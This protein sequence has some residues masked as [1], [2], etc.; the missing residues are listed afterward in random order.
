MSG[1]SSIDA[2]SEVT[3]V[4]EAD[5]WTSIGTIHHTRDTYALTQTH[6]GAMHREQSAGDGQR[7]HRRKRCVD[8]DVRQTAWTVPLQDRCGAAAIWANAIQAE[9]MPRCS[10]AAHGCA[11]RLPRL[12][13]NRP[14]SQLQIPSNNYTRFFEAAIQRSRFVLGRSS[15]VSNQCYTCLLGVPNAILCYFCGSLDR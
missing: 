14:N 4:K 11:H 10:T 15:P 2:M 7:A 1:S 13:C 5:L 12:R 3:R 9:S 8:S 6:K